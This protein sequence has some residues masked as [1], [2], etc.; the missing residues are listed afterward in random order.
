LAL[1]HGDTDAGTRDVGAAGHDLVPLDEFV[2]RRAVGQEHVD[3]LAALEAGDQ[4]AGRAIARANG[5]AVRAL[6]GRQ[7]FVRRRLDR[8][9]DEGVDL[10]GA[11]GRGRS[12]HGDDD[13]NCA[14][15]NPRHEAN[16]PSH[17]IACTSVGREV[18]EPAYN[19]P[20]L[21]GSP[22]SRWRSVCDMPPRLGR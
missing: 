21:A 11:G 22:S 7:Q 14:H 5:M 8:G 6:E 10:G 19:P 2:D 17:D 1:A 3:G 15:D 9:R 20:P 13:Y 4:R 18:L 12:E 16:S